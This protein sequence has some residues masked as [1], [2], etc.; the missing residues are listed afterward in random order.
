MHFIFMLTHND[1]TVDN[2]AEVYQELRDTDL[3]MVGFKDVGASKETLESL[4][5]MIH[6]DGRRMFLEVVST[7]KDHELTSIKAALDA[8]V[9][10]IIGG[11]NHD[12]ALSLLED[13]SV[14]YCPFIGSIV[15][16]PSELQGS[17]H[18]I[19]TQTKEVSSRKGVYGLDLLAYRHL[20]VDPVELTRCV[21]EASAGPVIAAGSVDSAERIAAL[22]GAGA[23]AFTIGGAIFENRLPGAPSVKAQVE[24]ALETAA[25]A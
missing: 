15:G 24:W 21:A 14:R 4:T 17:I 1:R 13:S 11:T 5:D 6:S 18:D 25:N 9:D 2:A 16:H 3:Q 22:K 20:H 8:G 10:Y 23:W 19:V 12:D 7:S